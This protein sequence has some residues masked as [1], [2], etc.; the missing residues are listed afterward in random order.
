M[1]IA[2]HHITM[3]RPDPSSVLKREFPELK[4]LPDQ[5]FLVGG[6]VRDALL[7]RPP[8]DLDL[9]CPTS[10]AAAQRFARQTGGRL[11]ELGRDPMKVSRVVV[12]GRI[13]DFSELSEGGL[14][15][16]LLRRDFT[17]NG[18]AIALNSSKLIDPAVGLADLENSVLR[19]IAPRNFVEDPLRVLRGVRLAKELGFQIEKETLSS[20]SAHAPELHS[21]APER[22]RAELEAILTFENAG[23]SISLM[24]RLGID[25]I[26]FGFEFPSSLLSVLSGERSGDLVLRLA[27]IM[28]GVSAAKVQDFLARW[29]WSRKTGSE[30]DALLR[31][32]ELH[33][34]RRLIGE[35]LP[36]YLHDAGQA[37]AERL[38]QLLDAIE[39]LDSGAAVR[40]AMRLIEFPTP[41]LLSGTEIAELTGWEEGP[42][43]GRAK[44]ALLEAQLRGEIRLRE[45]AVVFVGKLTSVK[46]D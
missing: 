42:R 7:G 3:L 36:L 24:T 23:E 32:Y 28:R 46:P 34:Q 20:M 6:A 8:K 38:A 25:E 14:E 41:S 33:S 40:R 13:Y 26:V 22:V 11:I 17:V 1:P 9:V 15:S 30:L 21:V 29:R 19:M 27:L 37:T 43:I 2:R 45:E 18:L 10:V 31:L 44:R 4:E 5:T 12:S 39:E 35:D 16:E